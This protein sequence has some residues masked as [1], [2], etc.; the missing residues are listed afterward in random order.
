MEQIDRSE[1]PETPI[2]LKEYLHLFW[3]WA[4]LIVLAGLVAGVTAYFISNRITPIYEII[5]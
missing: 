2:D 3:S 4:W 1:P 5:D